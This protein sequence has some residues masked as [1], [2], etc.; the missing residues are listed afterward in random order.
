M[1]IIA[2]PGSN[3]SLCHAA[4]VNSVAL[5]LTSSISRRVRS[6]LMLTLSRPMAGMFVLQSRAA[7]VSA[8][9][10]GVRLRLNRARSG[11]AIASTCALIAMSSARSAARNARAWPINSAGTRSFA[12]GM[13]SSPGSV[14]LFVECCLTAISRAASSASVWDLA[15]HSPTPRRHGPGDRAAP[16][17]PPRVPASPCARSWPWRAAPAAPRPRRARPMPFT[18]GEALGDVSRAGALTPL[19]RRD[20]RA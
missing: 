5:A 17:S 10:R 20:G 12:A 14:P 1:P 9:D 6:N 3:T 8:D 16:Q 7:S 15:S 13:L 19:R 18:L 11:A 4:R 2:T